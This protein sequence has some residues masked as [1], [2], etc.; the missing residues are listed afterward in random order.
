VTELTKEEAKR[1][2]QE[3]ELQQAAQDRRDEIIALTALIKGPSFEAAGPL[4][5]SGARTVVITDDV[6]DALDHLE[7]VALTDGS[8]FRELSI[9]AV[10]AARA[11]RERPII[12]RMPTITAELMEALEQL[13]IAD[14][15][16]RKQGGVPLRSIAAVLE[17]GKPAIEMATKLR[18]FAAQP[19][20]SITD[21]K[22]TIPT[23]WYPTQQ[24]ETKDDSLRGAGSQLRQQQ[25]PREQPQQLYQHTATIERRH[26]DGKPTAIVLGPQ[27]PS[28]E[29]KCPHC[30]QTA[31]KCYAS[32]CGQR[33]T[34]PRDRGFAATPTEGLAPA[35]IERSADGTP[36]AIALGPQL[37]T[38]GQVT[39][40]ELRA[41]HAPKSDPPKT[42]RTS[43][44]LLGEHVRVTLRRGIAGQRALIGSVVFA[45][46][47]V[48]ALRTD[49]RDVARTL[50][51][52]A[53]QALTRAL[54]DKLPPGM[55]AR[56]LMSLQDTAAIAVEGKLER[57][58]AQTFNVTGEP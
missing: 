7:H 43:T 37:S 14:A 33:R 16:I 32:G 5:P 58:L 41:K 47:D 17:A 53:V 51:G 25:V 13:S 35:T 39:Y 3:R 36:R 21:M 52:A 1:R 40:D 9:A 48:E 54:V 42:W 18:T 19:R 56:E 44:E 6:I 27:L 34:P 46:E 2:E 15:H 31:E 57:L 4:L 45:R 38:E 12:G 50:A 20:P 28:D 29:K 11:W 55:L 26:T 23:P 8:D 10:N 30:L 49:L 22:P 24:H